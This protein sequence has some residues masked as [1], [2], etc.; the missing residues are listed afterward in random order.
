MYQAEVLTCPAEKALILL[1]PYKSRSSSTSEMKLR[2]FPFFLSGS[3]QFFLF[4]LL[5][6]VTVLVSPLWRG[7]WWGIFQLCC[8]SAIVHSMCL[9]LNYLTR[10]EQSLHLRGRDTASRCG[11]EWLT[12]LRHSPWLWLVVLI[13]EQWILANQIRATGWSHR[14]LTC[15]WF[16]CQIT[17]TILAKM[18]KK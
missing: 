1:S 17:M 4:T 18:T 13:R 5:F 15:I 16:Y 7:Q 3:D 10:W 9:S 11:W 2:Y 12:L 14:Q 8:F 6:F